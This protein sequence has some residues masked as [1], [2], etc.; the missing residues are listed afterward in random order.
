MGKEN[1]KKLT[2]ADLL[3]KKEQRDAAKTEYQDVEI[4]SL[5]GSLTF[6]K[7]P[8]T[9]FLS[10]M[11]GLEDDAG[12]RESL[13]FSVQL[14]YKCCPMLRDVQLREAY[15]CVEPTDVVYKVFNDDI[16]AINAASAAIMDF[17]GVG[18]S[19]REAL[20]N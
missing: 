19:V 3:A 9:E 12:V 2:L 16:G 4:P 14:I 20:K 13:D 1:L 8:L 5:G 17:Y 7:L 6:R 18:E 10:M 11:E 15:G